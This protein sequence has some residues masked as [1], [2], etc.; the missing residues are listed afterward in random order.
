MTEKGIPENLIPNADVD[1]NDIVDIA[2]LARMK[3]YVSKDS[4]VKKLCP[5]T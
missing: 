4:A 1:G 5:S 3:Q 2:D